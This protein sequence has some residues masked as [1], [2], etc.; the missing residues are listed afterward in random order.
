MV[1]FVEAAP[2][3]FSP[4]VVHGGDDAHTVHIHWDIVGVAV[5]V[6]SAQA[7]RN[8]IFGFPVWFA[9]AWLFLRSVV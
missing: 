1:S 6:E 3:A 4:L 8:S 5:N 2:L 7:D 9:P